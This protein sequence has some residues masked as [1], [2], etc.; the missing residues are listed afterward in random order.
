MLNIYRILDFP[1]L[2]TLSQYIFSPGAGADISDIIH[3]LLGELP[4]SKRILDVGCGPSSWLF[5]Q[6]IKPVGLDIN[7]LYIENYKKVNAESYVGSSDNLP[8]KDQS[9]DGIWSIALLHHLSDRQARDSI[10]EM[11]RVCRINGYVVILDAVLPALSIR[12][13]P[14]YL[15]RKL[16]RGGFVRNELENKRIFPNL[17]SWQIRRYIYSY[18]GLEIMVFIYRK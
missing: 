15:I 5:K 10:K 3:G 4:K 2:Y 12:R 7:P 17:H 13:L 8:F 1:P 18:T 6:N 14:A 9:F 16:D 11:M